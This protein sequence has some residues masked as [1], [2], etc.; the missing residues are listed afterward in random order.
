M[1]HAQLKWI[2]NCFIIEDVPPECLALKYV[3]CLLKPF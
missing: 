3:S 1:L 2:P